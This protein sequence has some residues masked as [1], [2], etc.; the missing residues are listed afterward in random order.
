LILN[1]ENFAKQLCDLERIRKNK[2]DKHKNETEWYD[3]KSQ[4][5]KMTREDGRI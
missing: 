5:G 2:Q 3:G 4:K 1:R